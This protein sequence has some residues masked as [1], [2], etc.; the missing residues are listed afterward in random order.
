M[1]SKDFCKRANI[2]YRC[3]ILPEVA[4]LINQARGMGRDFRVISEEELS[5][6]N[7][8]VKERMTIIVNIETGE[9]IR[10]YWG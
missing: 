5:S 3:T 1:S 10:H 7:V 9:Y 2:N 6:D 4:K 8:V